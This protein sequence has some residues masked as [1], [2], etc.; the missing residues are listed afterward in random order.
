LEGRRRGLAFLDYAHHRPDA[1]AHLACGLFDGQTAVPQSDYLSAVENAMMQ[2]DRRRLSMWWSCGVSTGSPALSS[3]L[4]SPWWSPTSLGIDFRPTLVLHCQCP[5]KKNLWRRGK[6]GRTYIDDETKAL[7][8]AQTVQAQS[9][10]KH[11]PVKHPWISFQFF[12]RDRRRD[13]DNL[14]TTVLVACVRL[15]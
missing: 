10:W 15:A 13:R 11:E 9:R 2:D 7:I 12:T 4:C 8:D 1:E 6:G 5:S 14:L 3:G